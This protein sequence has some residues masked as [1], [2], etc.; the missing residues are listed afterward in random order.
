MVGLNLLQKV[1]LLGLCCS[2]LEVH[3][4]AKLHL[5][6]SGNDLLVLS[7]AMSFHLLRMFN[8]LKLLKHHN[9]SLWVSSLAILWLNSDGLL[10]RISI[11][12]CFG[13]LSRF[14]HSGRAQHVQT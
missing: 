14:S 7:K 6:S 10:A 3:V 13:K 12:P 5:L 4:V 9:I 8:A 11:F 1:N 2:L